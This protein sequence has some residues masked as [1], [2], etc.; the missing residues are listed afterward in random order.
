MRLIGTEARFCIVICIISTNYKI[1]YVKSDDENVKT[2][3]NNPSFNALTEFE[4]LSRYLIPFTQA[5]KSTNKPY[6]HI[7]AMVW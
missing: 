2:E 6:T 5:K 4:L 7:I 1:Q 3:N